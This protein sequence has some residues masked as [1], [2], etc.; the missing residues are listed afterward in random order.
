MLDGMKKG[1]VRNNQEIFEHF[2]ASNAISAL[3]KVKLKQYE[4]EGQEVNA[5][6]RMKAHNEARTELYS[7]ANED[8]K[9]EIQRMRDKETEARKAEPEVE[10]DEDGNP[11]VKPLAGEEREKFLLDF[12]ET[13]R[14]FQ[15]RMASLGGLAIMTVVAKRDQRDGI[16]HAW[17]IQTGRN[18]AGVLFRDAFPEYTEQIVRPF[19]EFSEE[20][21]ESLPN[22]SNS[23]SSDGIDLTEKLSDLMEKSSEEKPSKGD[24]ASDSSIDSA[25]DGI[26]SAQE[27]ASLTNTKESDPDAT[28]NPTDGAENDNRT[29]S[30]DAGDP[31]PSPKLQPGNSSPSG[32]DPGSFPY[33]SAPEQGFFANG[34]SAP[35]ALDLQRFRNMISQQHSSQ[36]VLNLFEHLAIPSLN[37]SNGT[38]L[39]AFSNNPSYELSMA[40]RDFFQ[41]TFRPWASQFNSLPASFNMTQSNADTEIFLGDP[42]TQFGDMSD[43]PS[44][45]TLLSRAPSTT[46]QTNDFNLSSL[47][48]SHDIGV[49]S[50]QYNPTADSST[51]LP[52][53]YIPSSVY[54]AIS[55]ASHPQSG[56]NSS[57]GTTTAVQTTKSNQKRHRGP[58]DIDKSAAEGEKKRKGKRGGSTRAAGVKMANDNVQE[59]GIGLTIISRAG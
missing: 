36:S 13:F 49:T 19:V 50:T 27:G 52:P 35:V 11:K 16:V 7:K 40:E 37:N 6:L 34:E 2:F 26:D 5:G 17:G 51:T 38:D 29:C 22:E 4:S 10:F 30:S 56:L 31:L 14:R 1:R 32:G 21:L 24:R 41:E 39:G 15:K 42:F 18:K 55:D 3:Q 43:M 25:V 23:D 28:L 12:T 59:Q 53:N 58:E 45:E 8:T 57:V 20:V 47:F 54:S 48:D 33:S 46:S 9:L 44:L